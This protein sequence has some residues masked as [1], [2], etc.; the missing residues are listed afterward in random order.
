MAMVWLAD[1]LGLDMLLGA[2]AAG[3]VAH[4][5]VASSSPREL[6]L[7]EAKLHGIGFGFFVPIFFVV[8]GITFDL[9]SVFDDPLVLLVVPLV[10]IAF[11]V[12]RGT[13]T[14]LMQREMSRRDRS[15]WR[16]ISPPGCRSWSSSRRSACPE[17]ASA[18]RRPRVSWTAAMIS[19]IVYPLLA[20]RC[21][22]TPPTFVS[23]PSRES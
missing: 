3:M 17:G 23:T 19:V 18:R 2:F 16:A 4:L 6:E 7:V 1:E 8:S 21:R 14:A 11:L 20:A 12:V 22:P 9:D 5:F 10:L 13:P 15:R